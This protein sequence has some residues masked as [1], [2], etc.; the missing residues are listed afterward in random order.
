MLT[1]ISRGLKHLYKFE[2]LVEVS[3]QIVIFWMTKTPNLNFPSNIFIV[4]K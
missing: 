2:T 3:V 1:K 4:I